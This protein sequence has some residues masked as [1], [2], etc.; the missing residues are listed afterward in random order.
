VE[1]EEY[2]IKCDHV[3]QSLTEI[4]TDFEKFRGD[5]N[6]DKIEIIGGVV[7]TPKIQKILKDF[8]KTEIG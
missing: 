5:I 8:Y 3:Y 4:L 2:E 1:K 6:Y 7:R